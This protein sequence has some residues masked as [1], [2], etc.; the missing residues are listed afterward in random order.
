MSS[1]QWESPGETG[2]AAA[3]VKLLKP[4]FQTFGFLEHQSSLDERQ[5]IGSVVA[6]VILGKIWIQCWKLWGL[7]HSYI[8]VAFLIRVP[9]R[10]GAIFISSFFKG[11]SSLFLWR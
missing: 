7:R 2:V 9:R 5:V 1:F 11:S 10:W 6:T 3:R 4:S 8:C